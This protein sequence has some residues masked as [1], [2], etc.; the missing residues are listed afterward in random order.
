MRASFEARRALLDLA[1][2]K[3]RKRFA[4]VVA[5]AY[6]LLLISIAMLL[7][8]ASL[9]RDAYEVRDQYICMRLEA[10]HHLKEAI[11]DLEDA[12]KILNDVKGRCG[13][14]A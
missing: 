9:T 3:H 10:D 12:E 7:A 5:V 11:K 4:L 1:S 13:R 8:T 14:A 2:D 6:L